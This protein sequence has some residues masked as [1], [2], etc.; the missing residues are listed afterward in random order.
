MQVENPNVLVM[1]NFLTWD[2]K[3]KMQPNDTD[4]IRCLYACAAGHDTEIKFL[5][6]VFKDKRLKDY[7]L[8]VRT[9]GFIPE[10]LDTDNIE[11]KQ[12]TYPVGLYQEKIQTWKSDIYL[13]PLMNDT[14]FSRC[15][16]ELKLLEGAF[17]NMP[18]VASN[19]FTF[20]QAINPGKIA[21]MTD[22]TK[23]CWVKAILKAKQFKT[24]GRKWIYK[25]YRPEDNAERVISFLNNL[26]DNKED[27][28]VI[29][30][31]KYK[32]DF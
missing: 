15:K 19:I 1:R 28:P 27:K 23:E 9:G 17:L 20:K 24:H 32:F 10:G 26:L 6:E 4:K 11:I 14:V 13:A 31:S 29:E 18:I 21:I 12:V 8:V 25:N 2:K 7:K 22:N 30:I 3:I 16:S 5:N